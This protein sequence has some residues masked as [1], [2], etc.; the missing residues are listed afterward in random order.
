[1]LNLIERSR[2]IIKY[3]VFAHDSNA[4]NEKKPDIFKIKPQRKKVY[5]LIA[6]T[7]SDPNPKN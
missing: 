3:I 1:M 4:V 2:S 6:V 5:D 7:L